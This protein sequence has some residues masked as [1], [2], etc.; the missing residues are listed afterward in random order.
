MEL[1]ESI[2]T[3]LNKLFDGIS[4]LLEAEYKDRLIGLERSI[5]DF[6]KEKEEKVASALKAY[7]KELDEVRNLAETAKLSSGGNI[8]KIAKI[9]IQESEI[10]ELKGKVREIRLT[11]I[12]TDKSKGTTTVTNYTKQAS[13]RDIGTISGLEESEILELKEKIGKIEEMKLSD[14]PIEKITKIESIIE[15]MKQEDKNIPKEEDLE[16]LE[17]LFFSERL[18]ALIPAEDSEPLKPLLPDSMPLKTVIENIVYDVSKLEKRLNNI[19]ESK[20]F[21]VESSYRRGIS[22]LKKKAYGDAKKCFEEIITMNPNLK[23][24]WL[25]RGVASGGL[26]DIKEEI[27]CYTIALRK[28]K[29]YEKALHNKKIAERKIRRTK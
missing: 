18:A 13:E 17:K 26:G 19:R 14:I 7:K 11:D 24:A 6:K 23:G 16:D 15:K 8:E 2:D 12:P 20:M 27:A 5:E 9:T 21:I 1:R 22:L 4:G 28:D 3:I 10:E 25:N 29:N